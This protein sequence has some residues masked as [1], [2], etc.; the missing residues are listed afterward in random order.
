MSNNGSALTAKDVQPGKTFRGKNPRPAGRRGELN[1]RT[2]LW[3]SPYRKTVQYDSSA[4]P[5][6]RAYPT[7]NIET[8]L[9][10][11]SHEVDAE[12]NPVAANGR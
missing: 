12:G 11:A 10:W 1:D 8:F 3:V 2:I 6:G 7:V 5:D 4:V 9:Q